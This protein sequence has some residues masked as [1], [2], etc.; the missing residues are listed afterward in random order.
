MPIVTPA[1]YKQALGRFVSGVTVV[2][3]EFGGQVHGMTASA[4]L[5]VSLDPPLVLV[6]VARSAKMHAL[7]PAAGRFAVSILSAGQQALSSHFAGYGDAEVSWERGAA[8][9]PVVLGCLG[10]VDCLLD[11]AHDAGDHTL[12]L[13]RVQRVGWAEAEPLTYYRGKYRGLAPLD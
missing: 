3:V 5:S 4:F 9:S 13:G 10:W 6:S 2:A 11:A 7:M 8:E 1:D 12:Y